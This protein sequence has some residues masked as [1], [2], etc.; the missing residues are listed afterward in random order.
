[1]DAS[2]ANQVSNAVAARVGAQASKLRLLVLVGVSLLALGTYYNSLSGGFVQD[3]TPQIIENPMMEKANAET[4]KRAFTRDFWANVEPDRARDR[5]DSVYYRPVFLLALMSGYRL[6]G[7]NASAWHFIAVCLH[8]LAAILAFLAMDKILALTTNETSSSRTLMSA[9]ATAIFVVHPVQSESAAWISGLVGPLSTMFMLGAFMCYLA[10]RRSAASSA[11]IGAAL[12]FLIATFTKE[13]TLVLPLIIL[14]CEFFAFRNQE[15]SKESQR[16]RIVLIAMIG[17][18]VIYL[19]GRYAAIGALLGRSRNLNFPDDASLTL[20]D[21]LRTLPALLLHYCKLVVYPADLSFLY[22][23]GYVRTVSFNGFWL[24][25]AAVISIAALIIYGARRSQATAIAVVWMVVPLVPHLNTRAFVS[26]EIIHDR[27]MYGSMIGIGILAALLLW[28]ITA[29]FIVRAS[30]AGLVVLV[31]IALTVQQNRQWRTNESLW[32]RAAQT[33]PDSRLVHLA[34]A[35]LAEKR[36]QPGTALAEYESVLKAH[37]DVIDALNDSALLSGRTGRWP[38]ATQ[39][40]E[41]IVE[42]TPDKAIAHYNLSFAYAVQKRYGDAAREQRTAIEL[43]PNGPLADE[44]R[45][46]LAQIEAAMATTPTSNS[47]PR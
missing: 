11:L 12:L 13:Q 31:L 4:L 39:K 15:T 42:L 45:S 28:R 37:P 19:V 6:A 29:R 27:Y 33:A 40:F 35:G 38:E 24:P 32:R 8:L 3:D 9:F 2:L 23:F 7:T 30:V 26:D 41:R 18:I 25:L 5:V 17:V 16:G 20:A 1:V 36:H 22:A 34:L 43:D 21:Q 47:K 10:Y 46:R 14:A 44:C